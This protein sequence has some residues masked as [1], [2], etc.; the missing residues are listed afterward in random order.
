MISVVVTIVIFLIMISLHE[1]G[2]FIFGKLLGF[3]VLEYAIGFGPAV[4]K[5]QGKNTLYSVRIIPFG[6]YCQFDGENEEKKG[7]LGAFN[8]QKCWKR[9]IVLAA[10]AV[11][12][13]ILG[14]II[15]LAVAVSAG[16]VY[17]NTVSSVIEN[18]ALYETGVQPGDKIVRI[19]GH[20]I[21]SYRD[22][23]L[24]TMDMKENEAFDIEISRGG[25]RKKFSVVPTSYTQKIEYGKDNITVTETIGG[26]TKTAVMEY[27][28][29]NPFREDMVGKTEEA[30]KLLIG[31]SPSVEKVSVN[32]I[33][34]ETYNMTCFVVKVVYKSLFKLVTGSVG[35][36]QISGPV[37]VVGEVSKAVEHGRDS[38][39][40]VL[41]IT[42]L[43]TINLGV[44]NLLPLPALDG[45]RMLFVIIEWIRRKPIPRDKEGI[46][47]GV[48]FAILFL[49]MI[50]IFFQDIM[51]LI[52]R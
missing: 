35:V 33:I 7:V 1:F 38:I 14:F 39:L 44:M 19:D 30:S 41:N 18:T 22:I 32:N 23:Q 37:G 43:L 2:H 28:E 40:Y 9:L 3:N 21:G 31:F 29:K 12:N 47:H 20:R 48:G 17:T 51:K 45:G 27:S 8:E 10:G 46:I 49:F 16:N 34:P 13:L 24:Y 52:G 4:F 26:S 50:F 25:E 5:K 11:F 6:G 15:Y 42:A 36:D